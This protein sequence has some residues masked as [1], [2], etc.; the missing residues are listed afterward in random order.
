M[1]VFHGLLTMATDGSYSR[2]FIIGTTDAACH[3]LPILC[4]ITI[5]QL[6]QHYSSIPP[7]KCIT[8]R[9]SP[10]YCFVLRYVFP[11][12]VTDVSNVAIIA[13]IS[14]SDQNEAVQLPSLDVI[15]WKVLLRYLQYEFYRT[16]VNSIDSYCVY[17]SVMNCV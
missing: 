17:F 13:V 4:S 5:F 12:V 7:P 8:S 9:P 15:Q 2:W 10:Q 14:T 3:T 11:L 1:L 16:S 6:A